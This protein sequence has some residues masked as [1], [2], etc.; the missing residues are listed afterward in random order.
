MK[1]KRPSTVLILDS[2]ISEI[3]LLLERYAGVVLDE[4]CDTLRAHISQQSTLHHL[5]SAA[6]FTRL[7]R[8][9]PAACDA[10]LEAVLAA[11]TSF[12]AHPVV[13]DALQNQA[14]PEILQRKERQRPSSLRIW[15]AG[16]AS[17]EEAYSIALTLCEALNGSSVSWNIHIVASD[18]RRAALKT[19]ERGLYTEAKL[20]KVPS[21]WISSYFSRVGDHFLVKP[22]LRNLIT[23]S[24]MNLI[25]ANFFGH[26]DCVF[27]LD[28]LPHL[29]MTHRSAL[30]ERLRMFLEPGGY[31]FVGETEK[32]GGD[33]NSKYL[34]YNY[35]RRPLAAAARS[36][37]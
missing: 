8:S 9:T 24:P 3:R 12:F 6:E 13:F 33:S 21:P 34:N 35:H 16:C 19:A 5:R 27:C 36:G 4:P 31:L 29:S 15:S 18:I 23:F 17:G 32:L 37:R 7:L 26:F 14:L 30:L 10:L 11:E 25:Q 20:Q 2:D 28:V 22:R 1:H